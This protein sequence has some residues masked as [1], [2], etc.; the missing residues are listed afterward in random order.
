MK[1]IKYNILS[2]ILILIIGLIYFESDIKNIFINKS[3][4]SISN[5]PEYSNQ[6]YIYI[7]NNNPEF[8]KKYF[9][10]DSFEKY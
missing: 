9:T 3:T 7:N 8:D 5:I 6:K 2:F 1:K 10:K 4:Y